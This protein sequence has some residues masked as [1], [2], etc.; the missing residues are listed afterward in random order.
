[1]RQTDRQATDKP[2]SLMGAEICPTPLFGKM[3]NRVQVSVNQRSVKR[4]ISEFLMCIS[5]RYPPTC[6]S[7]SAAFTCSNS[8]TICS[9][10]DCNVF[11][12]LYW[13]ILRDCIK[14]KKMLDPSQFLTPLFFHPL[15]IFIPFYP[16]WETL[17]FFGTESYYCTRV[18][19]KNQCTLFSVTQ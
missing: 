8:E 3:L 5:S 9:R 10:I 16:H 17:N 4:K 6:S 14:R 11:G 7:R 12:T 13:G 15:F 18:N 2:D 19:S 1:M